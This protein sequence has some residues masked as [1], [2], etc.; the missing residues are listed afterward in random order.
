MTL[1]STIARL[2]CAVL[3]LAASHAYAAE[4]VRVVYLGLDG[5]QYYEPQPAYTGLSLKDR[6]RP[7][8]GTRL[9]LRD[10]RILERSLGI[11][12]VLEEHLV[13]AGFAAQ[14]V[15]SVLQNDVAAILLDLPESEMKAAMV[16][17]RGPGLLFNIRHVANHWREA[18]CNPALL[19]TMPS[20]SMLSDAMAQLLRFR[21]WTRILVLRGTS[22]ADIEEARSV[23]GSIAKFG[24]R[25]ASEREFV[26]T[27]DPRRRDLNNIALLTGTPDYDVIWLVDNEGEFGR[28]VPYATYLPRPV[29]GSEGLSAYAWHWTWERHGA[30]QLNQRFRRL[31]KREMTSADWAGWIALR[32]LIDAVSQSRSADPQV[33]AD[34]VRSADFA[35]DLYKGVRGSFRQWDGQLRQ[36]IL[37]ATHN[38]VIASAPLEGFEHQTDTLDTLGIDEMESECRR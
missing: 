19:H 35:T 38:A 18:D 28:Y 27:N 21:N 37:L 20:Q 36:P 25:L 6:N 31:A 11:H 16:A 32:A 15:R 13:N 4:S 26:L 3:F 30:P 9:A 33:I 2:I 12:F 1:S 34:T 7:I 10:T 5:D 24:L 23:T 17:Y 22:K 8:D 14:A 29:V